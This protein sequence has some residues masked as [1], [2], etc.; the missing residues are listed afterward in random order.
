ME[1]NLGS[2]PKHSNSCLRSPQVES[3]ELR[4]QRVVKG[5]KGGSEPGAKSWGE[6]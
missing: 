1:R 5:R 4:E 6:F 2:V 3:I